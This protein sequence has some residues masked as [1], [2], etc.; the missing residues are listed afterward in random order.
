MDSRVQE[1]YICSTFPAGVAVCLIVILRVIKY[2][3]EWEYL[4]VYFT[5]EGIWLEFVCID[6]HQTILAVVVAGYQEI[7]FVVSSRQADV[8]GLWEL[9]VFVKEIPPVIVP[10]VIIYILAVYILN[11]YPGTFRVFYL[12]ITTGF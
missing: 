6:L 10:V 9:V 7:K 4:C 11:D 2:F 5:V 3:Q 8:V 12:V 1:V